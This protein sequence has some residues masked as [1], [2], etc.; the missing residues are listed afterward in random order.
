MSDKLTDDEFHEFLCDLYDKSIDLKNK[1][2]SHFVKMGK[3]L[4][5]SQY[6]YLF[7]FL[8]KHNK[9]AKNSNLW[10]RGCYKTLFANSLL[11]N[12]LYGILLNANKH[13]RRV[14][15]YSKSRSGAC[16]KKLRRAKQRFMGRC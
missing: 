9:L 8:R 7:K 3:Q 5:D 10:I 1:L 12:L 13:D 16:R 14:L 2:P 15:M 11:N 4:T 6:D